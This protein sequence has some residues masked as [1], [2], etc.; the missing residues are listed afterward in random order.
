MKTTEE[1][2][3]RKQQ[4]LENLTRVDVSVETLR[5][6]QG[7]YAGLKFV[8]DDKKKQDGFDNE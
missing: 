6:Y 4:V 2:E 1:I 5:Y 7:E 8:T 3:E